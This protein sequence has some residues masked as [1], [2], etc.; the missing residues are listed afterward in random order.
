MG[1]RT[2]TGVNSDTHHGSRILPYGRQS[3]TDADTAAVIAA[4]QSDFLTTGPAVESFERALTDYCGAKHAIAVANGTAALHVAMLAAGIQHGQRVLTSANT[5][6]AS[7]NCAEFVGA[8]ADFADIDTHT[9]NVTAA[10]LRAA[11]KPDVRAVVAVDFAGQPC[12]M[13]AIATLARERGAVVIEDAAHAIGSQFTHE[14]QS[15]K[16]GGHPWADLTTF[17][18][19]PVKTI[20]TGEGG[21]ILTNDDRLAERC[22]LFRSH[23]MI[24][25]AEGGNLKP[26][27]QQ[28]ETQISSFSPHPSEVGPWYYEMHELGYNYRITDLQCALGLSQLK[29]LD[30]FITRRQEIVAAYNAA[31]ASLPTVHCPLTADLGSLTSI[32]AAWHLYVLQL[33]FSKLGKT[34][35]QVMNELRQ[36][37]IGTQVHYIPVHLQPYYRNKY[38]YSAGKCPVAEAYYERCLSLPLYPAMTDADVQRV[39]NAVR[40]LGAEGVSL[41]AET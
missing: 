23:G 11:W 21:A 22:R 31:F 20:T 26:E 19:H 30:N 3:I 28:S 39:I 35:T 1:S 9:Y 27:V 15:Y 33:D 25:R 10:T 8:T 4:L 24:R 14:G 36:Q 18:F 34:R 41:R 2:R 7:A 40:G 17:S 16:V 13:P 6:L 37:G 29:K 12:D 5:F 32:R 38:G